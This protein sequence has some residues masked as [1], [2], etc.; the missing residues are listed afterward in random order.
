MNLFF[1]PNL[2]RIPERPIIMKS[3][4]IA[5]IAVFVVPVAIAAAAEG[6]SGFRGIRGGTEPGYGHEQP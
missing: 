2:S 5:A 6:A 1:V 4:I 3:A